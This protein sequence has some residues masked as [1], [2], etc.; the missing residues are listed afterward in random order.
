MAMSKKGQAVLWGIMMMVFLFMLGMTLIDPIKD[1][2]TQVRSA[3]QLNCTSDAITDG[4]KSSCLI[5]DL[6]LPYFIVAVFSVA[7]GVAFSKITG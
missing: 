2:V 7:G 3:D 5:V 1:T 6:M 4:A